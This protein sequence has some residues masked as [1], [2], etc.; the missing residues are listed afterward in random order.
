[1][2]RTE[3]FNEAIK[4]AIFECPFIRLNRFKIVE[5]TEDKL[6]VNVI[7]KTKRTEETH[8][9]KTHIISFHKWFEWM[10][11]AT[12]FETFL[13]SHYA[14]TKENELQEFFTV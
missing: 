7:V 13:N 11:R 12:V 1:M 5:E 14:L 3:E 4:G 10:D 9:G 2:T 8:V 6:K